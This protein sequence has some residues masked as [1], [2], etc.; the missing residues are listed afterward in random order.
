MQGQTELFTIKRAGRLLTL[1]RRKRGCQALYIGWL[2]GVARVADQTKGRAFM[3][4]LE[5]VRAQS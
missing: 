3:K 5:L 2:D 1:S 4:L